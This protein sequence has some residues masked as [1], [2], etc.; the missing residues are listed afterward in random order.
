[1]FCV[2]L[3]LPKRRPGHSTPTC[4]HSHA[5]AG[6]KHGHLDTAVPGRVSASAAGPHIPESRNQI[7]EKGGR[8]ARAMIQDFRCGESRPFMC[9]SQAVR[10]LRLGKHNRSYLPEHATSYKAT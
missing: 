9:S 6:Q 1:M 10:R 4:Q 8:R 2:H 7:P 5:K 3:V